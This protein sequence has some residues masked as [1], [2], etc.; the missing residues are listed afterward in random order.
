MR[1][2]LYKRDVEIQPWNREVKRVVALASQL[3]QLIFPRSRKWISSDTLK[4]IYDAFSH[5][6][7]KAHFFFSNIVTV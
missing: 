1:A 6:R 3:Y 2:H 5:E 4:R 7:M